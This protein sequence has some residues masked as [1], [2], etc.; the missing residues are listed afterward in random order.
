M[1]KTDNR[2]SE[3]EAFAL[4]KFF[5]YDWTEECDYEIEAV[6]HL[7]GHVHWE[8][9]ISPLL[10]VQENQ[11]LKCHNCYDTAHYVFIRKRQCIPRCPSVLWRKQTFFNAYLIILLVYLPLQPLSQ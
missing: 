10:H 1:R 6:D 11:I 4:T 5:E 9:E 3:K 2:L 7:H 8:I